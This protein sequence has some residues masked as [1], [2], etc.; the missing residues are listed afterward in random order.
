MKIYL[1]LSDKILSFSLPT[2]IT[3]S[4]SF[5]ENPKKENKLINRP[6]R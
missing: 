4:F 2:D 6:V 3:G 5:D 1:Y